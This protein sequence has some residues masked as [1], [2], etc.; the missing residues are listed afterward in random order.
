MDQIAWTLSEDGRLLT[1]YKF[2]PQTRHITP[3]MPLRRLLPMTHEE[4]LK[5]VNDNY[6][7]DGNPVRAAADTLGLL[8]KTRRP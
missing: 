2:D 1:I 7:M 5:F 4:A 6:P 8:V 3:L